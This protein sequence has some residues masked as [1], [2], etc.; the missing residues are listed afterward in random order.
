MDCIERILSFVERTKN[1]SAASIR[2]N[3]YQRTARD[4]RIVAFIVLHVG[5][6]VSLIVLKHRRPVMLYVRVAQRDFFRIGFLFVP[7]LRPI[8]ENGSLH[9]IRVNK[10]EK[11]PD[12][13]I[14]SARRRR[15]K[16][17]ERA[18]E[19]GRGIVGFKLIGFRK[20]TVRF[21]RF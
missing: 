9:G 16:R 8:A 6:D 15:Y 10:V 4:H 18:G 12:K 11:P 13:R 3:P 21:H 7:A 19:K 20:L 2:R 5:I 14:I 17:P 1:F